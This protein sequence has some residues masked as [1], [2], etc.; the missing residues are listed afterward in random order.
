MLNDPILIKEKTEMLNNLL[1]IEIAYNLLKTD[2]NNEDDPIDLHY[3]KLKC[4]MEVVEKESDEFKEVIKYVENTHAATHSNYKLEVEDIFRI[5]R[6]SE[7]NKFKSLHNRQLLWHGSRLT[8]FAGIL[9]QG[10]RIA[11]P[12]APSTGYMFGKGVYFADMVS[13]SANYC[14]T[15]SSNP[16]GLM[17][18]CD[19]ALG[20]MFLFNF[21]NKILISL[22]I[23]KS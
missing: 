19:V 10:L 17:L 14:F 21:Y 9:S 20:D 18:L 16:T 23:L 15:S 12:E 13:K 11:P 7:S 22:I 3:K 1:E 8:N 5:N 6:E 2:A 4:N